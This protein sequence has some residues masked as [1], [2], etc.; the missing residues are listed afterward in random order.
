MTLPWPRFG[1]DPRLSMAEHV[2]G[3]GRFSR[4]GDE[5]HREYKIKGFGDEE[6]NQKLKNKK[7]EDF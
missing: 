1:F 2:V 5:A 6:K 7:N 3:R 4:S